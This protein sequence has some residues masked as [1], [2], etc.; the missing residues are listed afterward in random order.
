MCR[1]LDVGCGK[2]R[3][4]KLLKEDVANC[5][6]Y[7]VDLS[8]YLMKELFDRTIDKRIGTLT[9]I[10]YEDDYF[11]LTYTCEALEHAIDINNAVCEMARVTRQGGK[12]IIVDKNIEKLGTLDIGAWEQWFEEN[13]L[14]DIMYKYCSD[15][16]VYK[17]M[18]YENKHSDGL[19][20][21]W[22]GIVQ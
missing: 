20:Y 21:V 13:T 4:L 9:N 5:Q 1:V 8:D 17:D 10:P 6:W 22:V 12:I 2:G 18:D 15:I 19:F 14:K 11:D 16:H 3:Y 7:A